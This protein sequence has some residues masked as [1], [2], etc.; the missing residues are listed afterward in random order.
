MEIKVNIDRINNQNNNSNFVL[1]KQSKHIPSQEKPYKKY[2][3]KEQLDIKI[4]EKTIYQNLYESNIGNLNNVAINYFGNKITFSNLFKK[5]D[6][7]CKAFTKL[8]VKRGDIVAICLPNTPEAVIAFYALNKMGAVS[9]FIHPLKSQNEIKSYLNETKSKILLTYDSNYEKINN[10]V[11]ETFLNNVIVSSAGDSM[12]FAIKLAYKTKC[13]KNE[14]F[15]KE[16]HDRKYQT[17]KEFINDSNSYEYNS[18]DYSKDDLAVILHTGGTTGNSK[19][20]KLSNDNFNSMITQFLVIAD[21]FSIGDKMLT[22]MPVFHGFGLCSSVH[23]PLSFGVTSVLVPKFEA[24]D[25]DKLLKKYK[26]NHI[27]GVPTLL[28]AM[29]KNEKINKM[30]LSYMKYIVTGGDTMLPEFEDEVNSFLKSHNANIKLNKGYG[31]S[32]TVAG[33]TFSFGECNI[34]GS[35]GIPMVK[36]EFK[37]VEPNTE[38]ELG[39]NQLGEFCISGS[40]VML[41]YYNNEIATQKVLRKH[42][43]GKMWLHT[44]DIGYMDEDGVLYYKQRND[45]MFI[46]SGVNVYPSSIEDIISSIPEVENCVVVGKIHEYKGKIPKAYV[47]I[48]NNINNRNSVIL[49]IKEKCELNLDKYHQPREIEIIDNIPLTNVG[50]VDY[51]LLEEKSKKKVLK[52]N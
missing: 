28:K 11:N 38:N 15:Y 30:D 6:I 8:G 21:N 23:L 33:S 52:I 45:R 19:S 44:G 26:P 20:V 22:I 24:K 4:P 9:N 14:K 51:R 41:G 34:P 47:V 32:E 13:L 43:D 42:S 18:I 35:V 17:W 5:I 12:P 40:T 50:K 48:K 7:C 10:I 49:N 25:F 27:I 2:Y 3:S 31:L 37:I 16:E 36:T 46:S 29:I 39:Y 1:D